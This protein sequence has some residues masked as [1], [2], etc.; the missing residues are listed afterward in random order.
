MN[1]DLP[2][3]VRATVENL[4]DRGSDLYYMWDKGDCSTSGLVKVLLIQELLKE[5]DNLFCPVQKEE[6]TKLIEILLRGIV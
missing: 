5:N 1:N 6:K 2:D 4:V 3:D